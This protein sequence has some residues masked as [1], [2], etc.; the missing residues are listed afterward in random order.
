MSL[1]DRQHRRA[2]LAL[3]AG[4]ACCSLVAAA[5]ERGEDERRA[6][7][8]AIE[9]RYQQAVRDCQARFA[10][11]ACQQEAKLAR[12]Q[13]LQPLLDEELAESLAQREQRASESR[14]RLR[15]KAQEQ[16]QLEARRRSEALMAEPLRHRPEAPQAA[17]AALRPS[18]PVPDVEKQRREDE[19]AAAQRARD[20]QSRLRK[21][22]EHRRQALE[23]LQDRALHKPL[24]PPLP[25]ASGTSAPR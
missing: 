1:P 12:Q 25:P 6:A 4:L 16:A 20:Q 23:R 21:A 19:A 22:E 8:S 24:A 7:R 18:R 3:A 10:V 13:A 9:Q 14:Q 2:R 17:S 5:G 11:N 15:V